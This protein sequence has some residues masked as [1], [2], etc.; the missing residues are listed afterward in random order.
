MNKIPTFVNSPKSSIIHLIRTVENYNI[1][2]QSFSHIL[3]SFSFPSSSRSLWSP[4]HA[5]C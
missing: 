5:H 4:T 1:F 2:S 3:D